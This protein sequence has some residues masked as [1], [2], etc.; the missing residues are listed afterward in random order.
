MGLRRRRKIRRL[1]QVGLLYDIG[2]LHTPLDILLKPV[3]AR[4]GRAHHHEPARRDRRRAHLRRSRRC[5][6]WRRRCAR[7]RSSSTARA[8]PDGLAGEAIPLAARIVGVAD[9]FHA[10]RNDRPYRSAL[11]EDLVIDE[12]QCC[13]GTQFDPAVVL[14]LLELIAE[15][16]AALARAG[17]DRR[18]SARRARWRPATAVCSGRQRASAARPVARVRSRAGGA[19]PRP[20]AR[21]RLASGVRKDR[22]GRRVVDAVSKPRCREHAPPCTQTR[23]RS[24]P[25]ITRRSPSLSP[26]GGAA[27]FPATRRSRAVPHPPLAAL[28][29]SP[30]ASQ[31][32]GAGR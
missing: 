14:A 7:R 5:V 17:R 23:R 24:S 4:R 29:R 9:A 25:T 26:E 27:P 20:R 28:G 3:S 12:L 13:A 19:F 21:I 2:K 11:P 1:G 8:I 30:S 10:M 15:D 31:R 22:Q 18:L 16:A 6:T 32:G